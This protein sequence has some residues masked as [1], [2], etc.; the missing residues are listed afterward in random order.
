MPSKKICDNTS[1]IFYLIL[2]DIDLKI[3]FIGYRI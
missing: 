1:I 3:I 2:F